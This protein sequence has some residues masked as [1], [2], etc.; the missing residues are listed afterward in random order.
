VVVDFVSTQPTP[1]DR[2]FA[3]RADIDALR[4]HDEKEVLYRSQRPSTMHACGHDAHTAIVYGSMMAIQ[5]LWHRQLLPTPP[6]VRA[7]FQSAEETAVGALQMIELGA[8]D[9]VG[10]LIAT[11]VDPSRPLGKIGL[12]E[13]VLTASCDDMEIVVAG[14]GGHAARPHEARDPIL[15]AAQLINLLYLQIGRRTDSQDAV[16][17]TFGQIEAGHQSNV[18]P[19]HAKLFGTLRTLDRHVRERTCQLIHEL[20]ESVAAATQTQISVQ[21]GECNPPVVNDRGLIRR[22]WESAE[23][24]IALDAPQ[25]IP[26]PSMGSEDFAFYGQHVPAAMF[27]LGCVSERVGGSG[28]HTATFDIDEAALRIGALMMTH[29]AIRWMEDCHAED[30]LSTESVSDAGRRD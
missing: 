8:L 3:M 11:H 24:A 18:I 23:Q 25:A 13:G 29:S 19:E 30:T 12:R 26:R 15:A 20:A 6:S 9:G 7:I 2:F 27:R 21:F 22:L 17:C 28:L 14:R 16:V 10:A 4:I 5:D 1:H